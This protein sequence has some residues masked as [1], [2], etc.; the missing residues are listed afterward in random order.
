MSDITIA[1][2]F[3]AQE[4]CTAEVAAFRADLAALRSMIERADE[5]HGNSE[6]IQSDHETRLRNMENAIPS[7]LEVRIMALEKFRWQIA[8][9][10]VAINGL[11][12]L[13]EW[14]IF[15]GKK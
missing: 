12:V 10:L 8:G 6:R 2:L 14:L 11:A 4:R 1:D 13:L 5:R 15:S 7:A 9:A 3:H